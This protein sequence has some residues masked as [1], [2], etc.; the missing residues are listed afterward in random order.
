MD[1]AM[2]HNTPQPIADTWASNVARTL[3]AV[4]LLVV[5]TLMWRGTTDIFESVKVMWIWSGAVGL[6]VLGLITA[7]WYGWSA[8]L[9]TLRGVVVELPMLGVL[10]LFI[11]AVVSTVFSMAPLV[12]WRG[13]IETLQGLPT[14]AALCVMVFAA[15]LACHDWRGASHI[16]SG[17]VIG[18][19]LGCVYAVFQCSGLDPLKWPIRSENLDVNRP[20]AMLGS[21]GQ[22]AA[23]LV[24]VIPLLTT[25]AGYAWWK[26]Q[27]GK[28]IVLT[29]NVGFHLVV[30]ILTQSDVGLLAVLT[31]GCV[32]LVGLLRGISWSWRRMVLG[33]TIAISMVTVAA[34]V[35]CLEV[36]EKRVLQLV[37]DPGRI[38]TWRV[39][40]RVIAN[41]PLVGSGLDTFRLAF[42]PHRSSVHWQVEAGRTPTRA[43]N[44][45]MQIFATQ[46]L[47]GFAGLL[48][49]VVA[50]LGS[51]RQLARCQD[52]TQGLTQLGLLTSIV[53]F[54][55]TSLFDFNAIAV[56]SVFAVV[57][58]C[59][60]A[61]RHHKP[62]SA[63]VPLIVGVPLIAGHGLLALVA[64]A[65]G[66]VVLA[67]IYY[68]SSPTSWHWGVSIAVA[69]LMAIS[70]AAFNANRQL[71]HL[72][73][74]AGS[75][76]IICLGITLFQWWI[77]ADTI[78][79]DAERIVLR[80]SSAVL[81]SM[82]ESV[83]HDPRSAKL[84]TRL[85]ETA[86]RFGNIQRA[87]EAFHTVC[88]LVPGDAQAHFNYARA[89]AERTRT[90]PDF[91]S[92]TWVEFETAIALDPNNADYYAAAARAGVMLSAF[93]QAEEFARRG[94]A[95]HPQCGQL[96]AI[97][98]MITCS[99]RDFQRART[100]LQEAL[101]QFQWYGNDR[102]KQTAL[103]AFG[104]ALEGCGSYADAWA[105][106]S[107]LLKDDPQCEAAKRG[108]QRLTNFRR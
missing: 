28:A 101:E 41:S 72:G 68:D 105:I 8:T 7:G 3:L 51:L 32:L 95:I 97:Q 6:V 30:L 60:S 43:H 31:S 81:D 99:Q 37:S 33:A 69:V 42:T 65:S 9:R 25:W 13:D 5:T 58:G 82:E 20:F 61:H 70:V 47:L 100:I 66:L 21:P 77:F 86:L 40:Q 2:K 83:R 45:L 1:V 93:A 84:W 24:C 98:G 48:V 59:Y 26:R 44:T 53:G 104:I 73:T 79:A 56:G 16:L 38:E 88:R 87:C 71:W 46:G 89:W 18:S 63:T 52:R 107:T 23:L 14:A 80:R 35:A 22:L 90:D 49:C 50:V 96:A 94:L 91:L 67:N 76:G 17:A 62:S 15:R 75:L 57:F 103:T 29:F 36:I 19:T 27:F 11:S 4:E 78:S 39:S 108:M 10:I 34:G 54:V 92:R 106:Y 102:D 64:G 12:S 55:M 85:G 74:L